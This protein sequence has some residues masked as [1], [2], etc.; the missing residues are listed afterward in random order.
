MKNFKWY[1][2][3]GMTCAFTCE[4]GENV[5]IDIVYSSCPMPNKMAE[6]SF[7]QEVVADLNAECSACNAYYS[8]ELYRDIS[9]GWVRIWNEKTA[10]P[11]NDEVINI[12]Q[13]EK[14]HFKDDE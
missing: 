8:I 7:N 3:S 10:T 2:K 9:N 14:E 11:L 1:K 4:C 5:Q 6:D 13:K 12:T